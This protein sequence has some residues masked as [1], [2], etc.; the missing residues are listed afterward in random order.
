MTD[1][2]SWSISVTVIDTICQAWQGEHLRCMFVYLK[3]STRTVPTLLVL[4][5]F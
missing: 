2:L 4:C 5:F 1:Q 3:A